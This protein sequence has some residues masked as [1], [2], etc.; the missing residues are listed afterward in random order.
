MNW[1]GDVSVGFCLLIRFR[2]PVGLI[3][4]VSLLNDVFVVVICLGAMLCLFVSLWMVVVRFGCVLMRFSMVSLSVFGGRLILM[5]EKLV[6]FVRYAL[7]TNLVLVLVVM[8]FMSF[9]RNVV[10]RVGDVLRLMVC[11]VVRGDFFF[12]LF[13]SLIFCEFLWL[14]SRSCWTW[15]LCLYVV[16]RFLIF[17]V[18]WSSEV[19]FLIMSVR[20]F[21]FVIILF[22][23]ALWW[24]ALLLSIVVCRMSMSGFVCD[25]LV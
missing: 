23:C 2:W 10:V 24:N 13:V 3:S 1:F 21:L 12:G 15:L 25:V 17:L 7:S 8:L 18:V 5:F 14:A 22:M 4:S 9:L 19:G 20:L 6:E 11:F 16:A